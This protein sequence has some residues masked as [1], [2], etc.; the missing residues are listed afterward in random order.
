LNGSIY[1]YVIEVMDEQTILMP[2][3]AEILCVQY[4]SGIGPCIWAFVNPKEP[5][6]PR[7]ILI[8]GTG[9]LIEDR[10]KLKY[11]GTFQMNGGILIFHAFEEV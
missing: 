4:Q 3:F 5:M 6:K 2:D 8:H 10:E 1:K 11:L 7:K 9:H